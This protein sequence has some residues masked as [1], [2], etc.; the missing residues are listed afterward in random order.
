MLFFAY[1]L[2]T[3]LIKGP[4]LIKMERDNWRQRLNPKIHQQTQIYWR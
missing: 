4:Q 2:L 1:A 3:K